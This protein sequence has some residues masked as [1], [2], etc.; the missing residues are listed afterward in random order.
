MKIFIAGGTGF[1]GRNLSNF[2]KKKNNTLIGSNKNKGLKLNLCFKKNLKKIE[3]FN[4]EIIINCVAIS[5]VD[6]CEKNKKLAFKTNVTV[7]KNL[8]Q[9]SKKLNCKFI[10]ISTDHLYNSRQIKN[11][12]KIH[13]IENFYAFTKRA[14]EK[15][16]VKYKKSLIIRTNFFGTSKKNNGNINWFFEKIKKRQLIKL[17]NDVYFSPLFILTFC[18]ILQ[19]LLKKNIYGI[20]NV[21]A[22]DQISKEKFFLMIAKKLKLKIKYQSLKLNDFVKSSKFVKRPRLMAMNVKKFQK[23]LKINLP[24]IKKEINKFCNVYKN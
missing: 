3:K 22:I 6:R 9:L 19:K 14:S 13:K 18:N 23:E 10:Q 12:E 21:G 20:F 2:L 24:T 5:N 17:L 7:T 8:V 15:E 4:P 1:L 16:A 11:T